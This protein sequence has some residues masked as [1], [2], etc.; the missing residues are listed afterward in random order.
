MGHYATQCPL[1]KKDKDDKHNLKAAPA[2]IK[3]EEFAMTVE[4]PP[5]GRWIDLE[6]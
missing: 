6:L 1:R 3:E 2:K 4:I 5:R